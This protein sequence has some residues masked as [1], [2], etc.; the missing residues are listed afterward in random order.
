MFFYIQNFCV[1][2]VFSVFMKH[3]FGSWNVHFSTHVTYDRQR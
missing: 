2:E 1:A 3:S